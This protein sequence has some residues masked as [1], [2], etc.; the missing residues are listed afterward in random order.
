MSENDTPQGAALAALNRLADW[1]ATLTWDDVPPAVQERLRLVLLDTLGVTLLGARLPERAPLVRAWAP[2]PG[3]VPVFGTGVESTVETAAWLNATALVSLEMD[4]GNKFAAG[5]PAAHGFPAVLALAAAL[6]TDGPTTAAALVVAYEVAA[7][8]GRAS[9]A[10]PGVH[11]HGNWGV[12]GAAAGCARLLGLGADKI[13]AAVDTASGMP[14]A[15][16]FS[17]AFD[18]NPVRN[19][20][21]GACNL[22]GL[23]AAR[24]AQAGVAHPTGIAAHSLGDLLGSF[25]PGALVEDLGRRWDIE[26]GYFKRHASCA[27]THPSADATLVLREYLAAEGLGTAD[28][29]GVRVTTYSM[30]AALNRTTFSNRLAAMFS[31]PYVVTTAL[32]HGRVA[33]GGFDVSREAAFE[34]LAGRV[35]VT[36]GEEFDARLPH[37]RGAAVELFLADGRVLR[38]E[39]ANPIG[40]AAHEPFDHERTV[41][42]LADLLGDPE[43]VDRVVDCAA[44]LPQ[45]RSARDVLRSLTPA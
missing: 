8:Y 39:V 10:R 27:F 40:D 28:V 26:L 5:H 25:D 3:P 11:P 38:H 23:A 18:G 21:M 30:A 43:T 14:I 19:E 42:L 2:S 34:A 6:D 16:H 31:I 17:A 29:T 7:R 35:E 33:P 45:A 20:W 41:A 15:G 1:S 36:T 4:E 32:L 24:L 22:A 9:R 12:T 44:A 13:A 37:A